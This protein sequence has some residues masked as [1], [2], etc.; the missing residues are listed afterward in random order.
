MDKPSKSEWTPFK[1]GSV[2]VPSPLLAVARVLSKRIHKLAIISSV[3]PRDCDAYNG[4]SLQNRISWF[5][6]RHLP[7]LIGYGV[8]SMFD[9]AATDPVK[10]H[11]NDL[12]TAPEPDKILLTSRPIESMFCTSI[13]EIVSRSQVAFVSQEILLWGQ[14]WGF[15]LSD[16]T[17][18]AKVWHGNLDN[19]CTLGMG[20][21][22]SEQL[23]CPLVIGENMG[24]MMYFQ[25][26]EDVLE[27]I[28][29][30]G[31]NKSREG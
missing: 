11:R 14:E 24:H 20:R 5:S 26:F 3:A 12:S 23:K 31:S 19:G 16:V 13:M 29:E 27:W 28:L 4:M 9:S 25:A 18:D 30:G 17:V 22:I 15:K 1:R 6:A 2:S 8:N 7:F 21:Y 10:V